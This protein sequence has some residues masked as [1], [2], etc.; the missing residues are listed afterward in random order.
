MVFV[1]LLPDIGVSCKPT[2]QVAIMRRVVAL[3]S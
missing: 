3:K 2:L 1:K